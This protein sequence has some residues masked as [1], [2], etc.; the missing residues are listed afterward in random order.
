MPGWESEEDAGPRAVVADEV[1][2]VR[3]GVA[4]VL[5]S[6]GVETVAETH[7][8]RDAARLAASLGAELVVIGDVADT[9]L[10]DALR[11]IGQ[12]R[13]APFAVALV[14]RRSD[15]LVGLL[16]AAA[17]FLLRTARPD[18]VAEAV[19]RV[20]KG[21]RFVDPA[22]AASLVGEV[23]PLERDGGADTPLLTL[24]EREILAFLAEGRSNREIAAALYVTL[25]TVKSHVAHVY[26]KLGA[27]NRNE[28]L[29]R[30]IELG[31]LR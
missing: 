2:L 15:P 30:A 27:S 24:R 6:I 26:A 22:L 17:G 21:E 7:A 29:G 1:A 10:A 8:G 13:P 19:Q 4:A 16:D 20:L 12:V 11:R 31:L 23:A 3:R 18:E 9:T 14:A 25:A 5:E 28:V